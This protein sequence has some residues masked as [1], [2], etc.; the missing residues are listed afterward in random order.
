MLIVPL[1]GVLVV[2]GVLAVVGKVPIKYNLRNLLVRWRM[3]LL[4]GLAFTVVIALLTYLLAMA[5]GMSHLTDES[6]HPANVIV[7]SDGATDESYSYLSFEDIGNIDHEPGIAFTSGG[8][9]LCSREVYILASMAIP[10]SG[11][12]ATKSQTRG[13]IK[14]LQGDGTFIVTDD[15]GLDLVFHLGEKVRVLVD[16][17]ASELD[18]AK[19]GDLLWLAYEMRGSDR[20]A[21]EVHVS[22]RQR[23]VQVRGV[24][25]T[26]IAAEVHNLELQDGEWF[27]SAGVEKLPATEETAIQAVLG[28][29]VAKLL[30]PDLN[31]PSLQVGDEFRLGPMKWKVTGILKSSGSIFGSEVWAKRSYVGQRY[32]KA[33]TLSSL[34]FRAQS[35]EAAE[36]LSASLKDNFKKAKLNPQTEIAYYSKQRGFLTILSTAILVL[37]AFMALGGIFGVMNTMFAAISQRTK[38]I[39]VLRILGYARRQILVSFLVESLLIAVVGGVAGCALGTLGTIVTGGKMTSVIGSEGGWWGKTV[40]LR[41]VVTANTLLIGALL[42]VVMGFLGG[43][44]PALRAMRLKPL[45]AMR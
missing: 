36:A 34:T 37:T 32:G 29:G 31:K 5:N 24:E 23:F 1:L 27:S 41:L 2:L 40:E 44:L 4:T 30:G 13:R 42:S 33:Y 12:D 38:D 3:T 16:A 43:L 25:D 45:E 35:P 18:F 17:V 39:G 22:G 19:P 26:L 9:P 28:E 15:K 8:K 20:V 10:P 14:R 7:M 21:T 11:G 6:G